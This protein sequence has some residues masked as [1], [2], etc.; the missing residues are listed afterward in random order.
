MNAFDIDDAIERLEMTYESL[1]SQDDR[2]NDNNT[3]SI[4][5]L[6]SDS[7]TTLQDG[8]YVSCLEGGALG[9]YNERGQIANGMMEA[10]AQF[11]MTDYYLLIPY[12]TASI[13]GDVLDEELGK[14]VRSEVARI[15]DMEL[16][17][18]FD[19][20]SS[21]GLRSN[22]LIY[23]HRK[24]KVLNGVRGYVLGVRELRASYKYPYPILI[25]PF[26]FADGCCDDS[27]FVVGAGEEAE[28]L[29][30]YRLMRSGLYRS[31]C[32]SILEIHI[33]K[34]QAFKGRETTDIAR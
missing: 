15:G 25:S 7:Y 13:F 17:D 20:A 30:K 34:E 29:Y 31:S 23:N 32:E 3:K 16:L 10:I 8:L 26:L 14:K 27:T 24:R 6:I 12:M 5:N 28:G 18:A 22:F 2:N 33:R 11:S 1:K 21:Q 9:I 4:L 19:I